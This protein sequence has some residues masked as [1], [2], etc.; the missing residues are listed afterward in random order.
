MHMRMRLSCLILART[1]AFKLLINSASILVNS[2]VSR[3][4][5]GV[6]LARKSKISVLKQPEL[7]RRVARLP[8]YLNVSK[9]KPFGSWPIF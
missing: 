6:D 1:H 4:Q 5:T 8:S 7:V 2:N 9:P 3:Q